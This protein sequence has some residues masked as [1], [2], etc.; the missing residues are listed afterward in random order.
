MKLND[1]IA[2]VRSGARP[3]VVFNQGIEYM[4]DYAE[5]GMRG[6]IT[7]VRSVESDE[8][9]LKISV[10]YSEFD[11]FNRQFESA[12]Y[13]DKAGKTTLTAREAGYYKP[14]D[15]LYL[16]QSEDAPFEIV[17]DAHAALYEKYMRSDAQSSGVGYIQWLENLVINQGENHGNH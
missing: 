9:L 4:E 17:D 8:G 16:T 7:G 14:A 12:N 10:D 15:T 3:V 13:Y 5:P 1:L 2:M 6:R 11:K